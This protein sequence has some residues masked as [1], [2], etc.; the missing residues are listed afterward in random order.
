[1]IPYWCGYAEA[2]AAGLTPREG[3]Q[4][5]RILRP[6]VHRDPQN[7][8][9]PDRGSAVE[10]AT[11]DL[12]RG[13]DRPVAGFNAA[14]LVG[15]GLTELM[16]QRRGMAAATTRP[17][18]ERLA[19]AEAVLGA[20]PVTVPHGGVRDA[21]LPARDQI[22]L[23][24]RSAIHSTGHSSR[25]D[26]ELSWVNGADAYAA[27]ELVAVLGAVLLGHRLEVGSAF[28]NR[29]AYLQH[30][31]R[32]LR[33]SPGVVFQVLGEA[34][35]AVEMVAPEAEAEDGHCVVQSTAVNGST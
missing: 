14:D 15:P 3:S 11:R 27:E 13:S 23:P 22:Q 21:D 29:A 4:A 2:K 26:R 33:E 18:V 10:P 28:E 25:L 16:A 20:W 34:R 24:I 1:V 6:Q 8:D 12:I 5:V 17:K 9:T 32:L 30:W 31:I 35:R 7:S 19:H